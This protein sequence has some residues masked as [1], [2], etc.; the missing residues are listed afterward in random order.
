MRT[1]KLLLIPVFAMVFAGACGD[2]GPSGDVSAKVIAMERAALDRWGKG[3]PQ[4][5]IDIFAPEMTYFDPNTEKRID[6]K[7]AMIKYLEPIKGLVK[8]ARFDLVDPKV[9]VHGPS[10]LLTF[11]LKSYVKA[12]D[13]SE[14]L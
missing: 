1:T 8:V 2:R 3:D 11:N 9:Q 12:P 13:G 5:Y 7:D 6:T 14:K 4:G 10:A